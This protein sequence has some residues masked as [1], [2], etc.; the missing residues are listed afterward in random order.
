MEYLNYI[1]KLIEENSTLSTY[2]EIVKLIVEAQRGSERAKYGNGL[3]NNWSKILTKEYGK[4]YNIL[5]L[6]K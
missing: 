1:K 4:G 5:N 3:I 2:F 6:K